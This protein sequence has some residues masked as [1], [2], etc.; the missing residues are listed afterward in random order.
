MLVLQCVIWIQSDLDVLSGLPYFTVSTS[1]SLM[2][3]G[4]Q[5]L[6]NSV[7][8]GLTMIVNV[9]AFLVK[10]F[11][12]CDSAALRPPS[13]IVISATRAKETGTAKEDRA[14]GGVHRRLSQSAS[15]AA[16][17]LGQGAKLADPI[18]E[19]CLS[20]AIVFQ[21]TLRGLSET[22]LALTLPGTSAACRAWT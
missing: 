21:T 17:R 4:R 14:D 7:Q 6:P 19:L 18:A 22:C 16:V 9:K 2:R 10:V 11:R 8:L 13:P 15:L 20:N 3:I 12:S 1:P 5:S